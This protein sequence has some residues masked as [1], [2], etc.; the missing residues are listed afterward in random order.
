MS[1]KIK[2]AIYVALVALL[3]VGGSIFVSY[4][5]P[6]NVRQYVESWTGYHKADAN[7]AS[8]IMF[9]GDSIAAREDWNVLLDSSNIANFGVAANNTDDVLAR[10]DAAVSAKPKKLFLI[11]GINDLLQGKSVEYMTNNYAKILDRI[12][13]ISPLTKLYAYSLLP[14]DTNIWKTQAV[15]TQKILAAN[16]KIKILADENAATYIDL[17]SSFAGAD[18]KMPRQYSWDGLHP[19]SHGYAVWKGLIEQYV[20]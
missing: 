13:V 1:Q 10:L 17:Y 19:N 9:L 14:M 6:M 15:D 7:A 18:N 8:E 20:K 12:E 4:W 2:I 3:I 16:E 11:I 5:K